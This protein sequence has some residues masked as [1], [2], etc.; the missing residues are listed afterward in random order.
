MAIEAEGLC[1]SCSPYL[2]LDADNPWLSLLYPT[3][4]VP[5]R[6]NSV[7]V[8]LPAAALLTGGDHLEAARGISFF[9]FSIT[10]DDGAAVREPLNTSIACL[11]KS[12]TEQL[13]PKLRCVSMAISRL[14]KE[15]VATPP[16]SA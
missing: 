9:S 4:L 12:P 11:R 5:C 14:L 16:I 3:M 6:F 10:A 1:V 7:L 13:R 15:E 8:G 2:D